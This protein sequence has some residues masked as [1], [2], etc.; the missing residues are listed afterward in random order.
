MMNRLIMNRKTIDIVLILLGSWIAGNVQL[1]GTLL[2]S[3]PAARELQISL[4]VLGVWIIGFFLLGR[5][6]SKHRAFGWFCFFMIGAVLILIPLS[7]AAPV[8]ATMLSCVVL[9]PLTVPML[10]LSKVQFGI[11]SDSIVYVLCAC[12][13]LLLYFSNAA[14]RRISK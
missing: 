10:Y 12:T 9:S 2:F 8:L 11:H 6:C 3:D 1:L 5:F 7:E 13:Y 14:G 4:A